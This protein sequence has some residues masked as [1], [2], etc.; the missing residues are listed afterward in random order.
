M[1]V[2]IFLELHITKWHQEHLVRNP[3][4]LQTGAV[5]EFQLQPADKFA[6]SAMEILCQ[7]IADTML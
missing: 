4:P 2:S 5:A 1:N 6:D 3:P 7:H